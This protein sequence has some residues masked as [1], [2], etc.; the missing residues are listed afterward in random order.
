MALSRNRCAGRARGGAASST[1]WVN[2][3]FLFAGTALDSK[4]EKRGVRG[5]APQV[6]VD[7]RGRH[8][9][10]AFLALFTPRMCTA[11][12]GE[13]CKFDSIGVGATGAPRRHRRA[14]PFALSHHGCAGRARGSAAS[15]TRSAW[16]SP[17]RRARGP[18]TPRMCGA[19]AGELQV[20]LDRRGRHRRVASVALSRH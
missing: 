18:L 14:A 5:G 10:A 13:H 7:R 9:R 12:A 17:A 4:S 20:R 16:A 6:R 11:C 3:R 15:S 19:C 8:R 2:N 1:P